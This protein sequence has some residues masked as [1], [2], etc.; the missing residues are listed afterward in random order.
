MSFAAA[1]ARHV[2]TVFLQEGHWAE[3]ASYQPRGGV[4]YSVLI[5]VAAEEKAENGYE[6]GTESEYETLRVFVTRYDATHATRPGMPSPGVG[7]ALVRT[8]DP[9][10]WAFT[11]ERS[12]ETATDW[13]LTFRRRRP[14]RHGSAERV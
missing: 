3:W 10:P 12:N 14:V 11:G 6:D 7:D 4:A 5:S 1:R 13:Q 2:E 8:G 9:D